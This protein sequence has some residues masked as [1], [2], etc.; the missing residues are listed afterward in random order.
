MDIP[1]GV[2]FVTAP[3]KE[4]AEKLS[5]G[6]VEAKLAACVNILPN[7][8]STYRWEDKIETAEEFFLIIK[9]KLGLA[10]EI[11]AFVKQNHP[12]KVPEIICLPIVNGSPQYLNW[13]GANTVIAKDILSL[14]TG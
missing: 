2:F 1:Y 10:P 14:V 3:N 6:L 9:S 11:S 13:V 7:V 12:H 4:T 5:R 8:T